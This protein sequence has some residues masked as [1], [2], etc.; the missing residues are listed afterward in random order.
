MGCYN[1]PH[2]N[3]RDDDGMK[4]GIGKGVVSAPNK[5]QSQGIK[6]LIMRA[7]YAQGLRG[8]LPKDKKRHE[9]QGVHSLR[10]ICQTQLEIAGV[11][12]VNIQTLMGR[13][14][15]V[16]DSY[17]RVTVSD[18]LSDYEK[19]IPL[20]SID[21][22]YGLQEQLHEISEK[23]RDNEYITKAKLQEKEEQIITLSRQYSSI[24]SKMET[25]VDVFTSL[26][27][28]SKQELLKN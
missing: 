23:N 26:G 8:R 12:N 11:R 17:Y 19:A 10:K 1:L 2:D 16:N 9:F 7:L 20:L 4:N 14:I 5:L 21:E 18:L 6:R 24:Q 22:G 27:R 13:S 25:L 3:N 28:D 15:G